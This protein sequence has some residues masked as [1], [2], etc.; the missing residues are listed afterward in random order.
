MIWLD[1]DPNLVKPGWIALII[2]LL[3]A[4]AVAGLCISMRQHFRR[5]NPDLPHEEFHDGTNQL[6]EEETAEPAEP[7][8]GPNARPKLIRSRTL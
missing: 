8:D 1:I 2:T 5:I 4:A 7:I 6:S 3:L